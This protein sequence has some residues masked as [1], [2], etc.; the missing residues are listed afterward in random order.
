[1]LII[2][3]AFIALL[4]WTLLRITHVTLPYIWH[5]DLLLLCEVLLI[6]WGSVSRLG[7][8]GQ[9][10]GILRLHIECR[11]DRFELLILLS[12]TIGAPFQIFVK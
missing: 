6:V 1:M 12:D 3:H 2:I 10:P 9:G 4:G 11:S 7:F 8:L 5:M